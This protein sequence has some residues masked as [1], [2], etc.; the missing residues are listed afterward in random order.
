MR[1]LGPVIH[2]NNN[3]IK[4][5]GLWWVGGVYL[6]TP[7]AKPHISKTPPPISRSYRPDLECFEKMRLFLIQ[8]PDIFAL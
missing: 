7:K 3:R 2:I 4:S 6:Y 8:T 5:L 1:F